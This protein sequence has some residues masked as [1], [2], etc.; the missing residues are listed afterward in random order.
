MVPGSL[1][2]L[3]GDPGVGKSTLLL[4]AVYQ[5]A[6]QGKK[7]LYVSGEES[8]EQIALRSQR[9]GFAHESIW[10]ANETNVETIIATLGE[11]APD[12]LVVDSIQTVFSSEVASAPGSVGQVRE[13]AA[14]FLDIAK[15][16]GIATWLVGHVT[17]EGSI[18]GPRVL[19]HLVDAVLYLEGDAQA[20]HRILRAV[21]N[22]FG[23]TGELGIFEMSGDGLI[24]VHDASGMFL[25]HFEERS[26]NFPSGVATTVTMEGMRPLLVEIQALVCKS[27]YPSPRRVVTG[28][29]SNR[30][31]ILM[32]VLEKRS[33]LYI[34]GSD[35][36][37]SVTGGIKVQDPAVDLAILAAI[38]SSFLNRTLDPRAIYLGEV[39]LSGELRNSNHL[40][41][42]LS[43]AFRIGFKKAFVPQV[44]M[45]GERKKTDMKVSP[46]RNVQ[47][48]KELGID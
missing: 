21:K 46:L 3:S 26:A 8:I 15:S 36:Y 34:G 38:A 13:C 47:N 17:K 9:L 11:L 28:L 10:V 45:R 16:R 5:I 29:D 24:G 40:D 30:T 33:G 18:A 35:V 19:E 6:Q 23:S 42:R 43:E 44:S 7:V 12:M 25:E 32:A 39:S 41:L 37:V 20:G 27:T 14:K 48:L 2:L 1:I 31:A 22:R 4:Q